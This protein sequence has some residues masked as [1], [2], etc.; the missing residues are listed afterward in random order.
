MLSS[1]VLFWD[2]LCRMREVV[3]E[4]QQEHVHGWSPPW[5]QPCGPSLPL[6]TDPVLSDHPCPWGPFLPPL[7]VVCALGELR[8]QV[9]RGAR[10]SVQLHH[11]LTW[12]WLDLSIRLSCDSQYCHRH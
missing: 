3:P 4:K 9:R 11:G 12:V 2:H 10:M 5:S 1:G 6:G 7:E 8:A